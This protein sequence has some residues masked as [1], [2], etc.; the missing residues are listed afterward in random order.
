MS[1]SPTNQSDVSLLKAIAAGDACAFDVFVARHKVRLYRYLCHRVGDA[2]RAED[3][4]QE[5]FLRIFRS[6][7]RPPANVDSGMVRDV[8]P[9]MFTIAHRCVLDYLRTCRRRPLALAGDLGESS[10]AMEDVP[11]GGV[12]P[13]AVA[14]A[15]ESHR[16]VLA[17]LG[18]LPAEQQEV[19]T[20]RIF[21][22]LSFTQI[23]EV[24]HLPLATVKSRMRYA[25]EKLARRLTP[26]Y[27]ADQRVLS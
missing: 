19:V 24:T 10:A 25:L 6:S 12:T 9:W 8:I 26:D 5:V 3:L 18:E 15:A 23:A 22:D 4:L 14:I 17:L 7:A 11:H 21:A 16:R 27:Q 1:E 13:A 20:L 2:H